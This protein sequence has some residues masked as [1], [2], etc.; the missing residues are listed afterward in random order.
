[1]PFKDPEKRKEWSKTYN[2]AYKEKNK[3]YI[4]EGKKIYSVTPQGIKMRRI[5]D[6]KLRGVIHDDF[7][8]LYD[9][10]S[11][12]TN[13]E[14]CWVELVEGSYGNNKKALDHCHI[15]GKMRGVICHKCNSRDVFKGK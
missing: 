6:W 7:N 9:Y 2:K 1:M 12:S 14:Y 3:E 11:L 10:Y 13:C 4:K 8:E 5:S 15:T